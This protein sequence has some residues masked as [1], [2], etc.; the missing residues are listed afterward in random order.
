M[1]R[2]RKKAAAAA[3]VTRLALTLPAPPRFS[4]SLSTGSGVRGGSRGKWLH[5]YPSDN[6]VKYIFVFP[7]CLVCRLIVDGGKTR[8]FFYKKHVRK[9][10]VLHLTSPVASL[11]FEGK[12]IGSENEEEDEEG[13]LGGGGRVAGRCRLFMPAGEAGAE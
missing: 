1:K 9:V 12:E 5:R 11:H 6:Y 10:F 3:T 4:F 7:Y 8:N 2:R 13:G